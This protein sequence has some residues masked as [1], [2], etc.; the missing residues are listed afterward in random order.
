MDGTDGRRLPSST[1]EYNKLRDSGSTPVG[2]SSSSAPV[3]L[4]LLL[5]VAPNSRSC[6]AE[7][8]EIAF[9]ESGRPEDLTREG[10]SWERASKFVLAKCCSS[11]SS[12]E[13][14]RSFSKAFRDLAT[15]RALSW[16]ILW[17]TL[18][19]SASG[20]KIGREDGSST[21][22]T[23]MSPS[24]ATGMETYSSFNS[25]WAPGGTLRHNRNILQ[26]D[27]VVHGMT[28]ASEGKME[29]NISDRTSIKLLMF[30]LEDPNDLFVKSRPI[31]K[32]DQNN[33]LR[34]NIPPTHYY[35]RGN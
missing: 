32:E 34:T 10:S 15:P 14:R 18:S 1:N 17:I 13:G 28:P 3:A 31:C 6:R 2:K 7:K 30:P 11:C 16:L 21:A 35:R 27:H 26:G 25:F 33:V 9:A 12:E 5:V 22:K 29:T 23:P 8:D 20:E 4:V 19:S 24:N